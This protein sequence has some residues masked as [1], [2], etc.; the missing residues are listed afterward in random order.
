MP[1]DRSLKPLL[2][3]SRRR[4]LRPSDRNRRP[5]LDLGMPLLTLPDRS[6]RVLI[7]RARL[8]VADPNYPPPGV[9]QAVADLIACHVQV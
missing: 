6:R 3:A 5:D 1:I 2:Q 4:C 7:A 8:L 9:V